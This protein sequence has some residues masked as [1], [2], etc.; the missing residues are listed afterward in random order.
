MPENPSRETFKA[1]I[2]YCGKKI[3]IVLDE[4]TSLTKLPPNV[5]ISLFGILRKLRHRKDQAGGSLKALVLIG[6]DLL[7]QTILSLTTDST[8]SPFNHVSH[9]IQMKCK[10][11]CGKY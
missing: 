3:S 5:L 8:V 10:N 1:A 2:S 9:L 7:A 6:T 4:A 11:G